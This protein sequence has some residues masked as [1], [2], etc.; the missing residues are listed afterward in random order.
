MKCLLC[1]KEP[2][3]INDLKENYVTFHRIDSD[4]WFSKI[5]LNVKM[6]ILDLEN[7]QVVQTSQ[8][9]WKK[10]YNFI[11]HYEDGQVKHFQLNSMEQYRLITKYVVSAYKHNDEYDF[12][13]VESVV[14][15]FLSNVKTRFEPIMT[16]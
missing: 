7:A 11:R 6:K 4:N 2:R 13:V 12:Y 1:S 15:D 16:S 8:G 9:Y 5:L 14:T 10:Y 3:N